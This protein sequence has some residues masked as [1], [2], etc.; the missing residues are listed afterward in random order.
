MNYLAMKRRPQTGEAVIGGHL[1][2]SYN[3][4]AFIRVD[5]AVVAE[6]AIESRIVG[7]R[8]GPTGRSMLVPVPL[9]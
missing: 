8:P 7:T 3:D 6:V 5:P 2:E 9:E 1:Y 4:K